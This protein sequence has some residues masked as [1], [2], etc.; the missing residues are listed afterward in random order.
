MLSV[1]RG[2][3]AGPLDIDRKWEMIQDVGLCE[4]KRRRAELDRGCTN[5]GHAGLDEHAGLSA[6]LT[7]FPAGVIVYTEYVFQQ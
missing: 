2:R 7:A 1:S 6:C 4:G 5:T 3:G